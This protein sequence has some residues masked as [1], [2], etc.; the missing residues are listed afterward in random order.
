VEEDGEAGADLRSVPE[1][2]EGVTATMHMCELK[3]YTQQTIGSEHAL[4][5]HT[6]KF[7]RSSLSILSWRHSSR[8]SPVHSVVPPQEHLHPRPSRREV[9]HVQHTLHHQTL[10]LISAS[11]KDL[12]HVHDSSERVLPIPVGAVRADAGSAGG[13]VTA[14]GHCPG[15]TFGPAG[16]VGL[17]VQGAGG[18]R[19]G[20]GGCEPETVAGD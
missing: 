14:R 15:D 19:G 20:C 3:R 5:D 18:G 13:R 16:W 10:P 7:S 4:A 1:G 8:L 9:P 12:P 11:I 2:G 17:G 6:M